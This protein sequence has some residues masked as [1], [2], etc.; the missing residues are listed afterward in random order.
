VPPCYHRITGTSTGRIKPNPM[1]S[2]SK[3]SEWVSSFLMAH[4][5]I[6]GYLVPYHG[7]VNLHK[8]IGYNQSYLATIK[9]NN[10]YI[11]W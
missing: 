10:K 3:L 7:M 8:E 11:V 6:S 2:E 4:Q 5:H 9:T 1:N